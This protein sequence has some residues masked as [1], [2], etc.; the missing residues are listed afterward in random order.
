MIIDEER[1]HLRIVENIYFQV[2]ERS[3]LRQ[4]RFCHSL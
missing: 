1:K 2:K 4:H 3:K